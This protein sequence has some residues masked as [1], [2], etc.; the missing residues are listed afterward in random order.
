M[1]GAKVHQAFHTL[2]T[3]LYQIISGVSCK[4]SVLTQEIKYEL[5]DFWMNFPW[6]D[7]PTI[8]Q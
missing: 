5:A 2:Q 3:I 8:S 6:R 4:D 7:L 1:L